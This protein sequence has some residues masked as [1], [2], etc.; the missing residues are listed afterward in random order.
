MSG[1]KVRFPL[2]KE[3]ESAIRRL[4]RLA[5][6]WPDTLWLYSASG[7]LHVMQT[8]EFGEEAMG[9]GYRGE[10]VDPEYDITTIHGIPN[11][12]GDW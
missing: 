6:D 12:G 2:T 3:E 5:K 10:G 8:D 4:K 1:S 9:G 11:D 7:N